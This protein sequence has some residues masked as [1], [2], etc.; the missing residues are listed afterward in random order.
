M[1]AAPLTDNELAPALRLALTR[2]HRQL[3]AHSAIDVTPSQISALTRLEQC[4]PLRLGALAEA[5]GTSP[6]T[7]SRLV[8][9]LVERELV[10]RVTDPEDGRASLIELSASGCSLIAELRERST[11]A[12]RMA[13]SE[14]D[15]T[16]RKALCVALP[17]LESLVERLQRRPQLGWRPR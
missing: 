1:G 8:D 16:D 5:E 9:A 14:M 10:A 3:R 17:A 15:A 12:L 4:G 2:L 6:S 13:L 7:V 11:A